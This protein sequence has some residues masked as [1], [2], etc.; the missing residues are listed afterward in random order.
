VA[1]ENKNELANKKPS[2]LNGL[3]GKQQLAG[4][5]GGVVL[6][7]AVAMSFMYG[8]A[9]EYKV[10]FSNV[11]DKDGGQ[12]VAALEKAQVPY[13][14]GAGGSAIMV[15]ADR[16]HDLRM[17]LAGEGLPKGGSVGFELMEKQKF[18]V[19]HF[20]EQINYQRALEGELAQT[21]GSIQ[22]V[23]GA[24]VHLSIPKQSVF[25]REAP[26]P[27]ASVVVNLH[28]GRALD[29][30]QISGIANLIAA[31]VPGMDFKGVTILD[32][33]GT[34]LT[35]NDEHDELAVDGRHL[36]Y[37]R[38]IESDYIKE[39]EAMLEPIVGKGGV[40]A[41]VR[42]EL[43][44]AK[45]EQTEELF[46]PNGDPSRASVRSSQ[47]M[48]STGASGNLIGGIPGAISNTP[49]GAAIAPAQMPGADGKPALPPLPNLASSGPSSKSQTTNY[50][51]DRTIR[52]INRPTGAV[53][54][55]TVAVL[56]NNK[57]VTDAKGKSK[58]VPL[59]DDELKRASK[60]V[61][62][63]VGF[64]ED[65]G[66]SVDVANLEFVPE[67][68]TVEAEVPL[69]KDPEI[70]DLAGRFGK[71]FGFILVIAFV[72]FG[73]IRPLI[74]TML[75]D[76]KAK[77]VPAPV[78]PAGEEGVVGTTDPEGLDG[79][80]ATISKRALEMVDEEQLP[81]EMEVVRKEAAALVVKAPEIA[82]DVLARWI[83]GEEEK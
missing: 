62:D 17:K 22:F 77:E 71:W 46:G 9:T 30:A 59:T 54:R 42:A 44:L 50:E 26:K 56:L 68:P 83:E 48:D 8:G 53:S 16:V 41:K 31:A 1:D 73:V 32:Q 72:I 33:N 66:D 38:R 49:P 78:L 7:A 74:K 57:V 65:R 19:S 5:L 60:L 4:A 20:A 23:S 82:A 28:S 15:P 40:R 27:S 10:L 69:W 12:I 3:T 76:E 43:D 36:T 25:V 55:V 45:V 39:I 18:G 79:A 64:K 2:F 80:T 24:R 63:V 52:K 37:Q 13:Q 34:P 11:S 61:Q 51:V 6:V 35:S 14:F 21:I 29:R 67:K 47:T 81:T 58:S 70:I 75:G